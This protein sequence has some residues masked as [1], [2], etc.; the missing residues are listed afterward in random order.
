MGANPIGR[1]NVQNR[2]P[3]GARRRQYRRIRDA[4]LLKILCFFNRLARDDKIAPTIGREK[5]IQQ[6]WKYSAIASARISKCLWESP[7]SASAGRSLA[8]LIELEPEK[9]RR[10]YGS[11]LVQLQM[12]GSWRARCCAEC[13]K[14]ELR[15]SLR[16]QER[17]N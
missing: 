6:M 2:V 9:F 1:D 3:T 8:R 16:S 12:A 13:L 15:E 14:K 10:V 11:H 17:D 5:E 7:A 4:S